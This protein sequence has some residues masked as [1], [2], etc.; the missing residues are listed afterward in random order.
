MSPVQ[1]L[2]MENRIPDALAELEKSIRSSMKEEFFMLHNQW[3]ELRRNQ[4]MGVMARQQA[5]IERNR[6]VK[7]ILD[8][9]NRNNSSEP[10]IEA[11][12]PR[13]KSSSSGEGEKVTKILFVAAN[14]SNQGRLQT[15][16][17]YS[18]IQKRL[19]SASLRENFDLKVVMSAEPDTLV[20]G[21]YFQPQILHFAGHG[22]KNGIFLANQDNRTLIVP[23][24]ALLRL[25]RPYKDHLNLIILNS[26]YSADQAQ[27]LSDELELHVVGMESGIG[28]GP[29]LEFSGG[30]YLGIGAGKDIRQAYNDALFLLETKFPK[31]AHL[32][33]V[34]HK[35]QKMDW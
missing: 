12:L 17:E 24:S 26:C 32:P 35:G 19:K 8:L 6:I 28:D 1:K 31:S 2:I 10:E 29:A 11:D 30:L 20:E 34:W 23:T 14:P 9:D 4:N 3:K 15:D 7:T 5:N 21:M 22:D 25:L 16:R 27:A 18:N 13:E 33:E